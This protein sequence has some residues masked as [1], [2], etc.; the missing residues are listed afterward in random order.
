MK[1]SLTWIQL[2]LK[3]LSI[4]E[5][6]IPAFL[7]AINGSL[8]RKRDELA[9]RLELAESQKRISDQ[10]AAIREKNHSLNRR[11]L[12]LHHLANLRARRTKRK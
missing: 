7:V 9:A 3:I 2:G 1:E 12:L 10:E 4:L 6:Y 8:A 5:A 11:D